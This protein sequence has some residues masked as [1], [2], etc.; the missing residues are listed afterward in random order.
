MKLKN[1]KLRSRVGMTK[2]INNMKMKMVLF[3]ILF[4]DNRILCGRNENHVAFKGVLHLWALFLKTFVHFL[5]K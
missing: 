2:T 1:F 3:V 5:K 4:S